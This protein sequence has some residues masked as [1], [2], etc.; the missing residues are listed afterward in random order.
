MSS[1]IAFI[2]FFTTRSCF[3]N[4]AINLESNISG[5]ENGNNLCLTCLELFS[6][7]EVCIE[8]IPDGLLVLGVKVSVLFTVEYSGCSV[9]S[10]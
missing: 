7:L 8:D 5:H 9:S 3:V 6:L 4:N 2:N 1:S 10:S